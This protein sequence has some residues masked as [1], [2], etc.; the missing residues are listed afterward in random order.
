M[1]KGEIGLAMPWR[2]SVSFEKVEIGNAVLYRGDCLEILPILP[3]VDAVV[4]DPPYGIGYVS[5]SRIQGP[6]EML[7]NDQRALVESVALMAERLADGGALYLA[8]RYDVSAQWNEAVLAAGLTMK[9]PIF[10]DKM[11]HTSG[12]L[13]GDYGGQVEIFI[14][15]HKGRHK[16]NERMTNLWRHSKELS[17]DHPT[18]KPV[19]L[20]ERMIANSTACGGL[21]LDA[22]MGSGTT[23]VACVNLDRKFIG[24][25]IEKKYFDITCQCIEQA[26]KQ[27]RL[28]A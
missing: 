1:F 27:Q 24:I 28:F 22:F 16:L 5:A 20:M 12:D 15:A 4:T 18:P 13:E 25:E 9:T 7:Q 8:T 23:G 21:V 11:N 17:L 3:K 6:T 2:I 26:K 19:G 10:W 14:F